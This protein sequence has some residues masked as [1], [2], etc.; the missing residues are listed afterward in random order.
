MVSGVGCQG[1]SILDCGFRIE[2]PNISGIKKID[3]GIANL[4]I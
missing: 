1:F 3:S 2:S 4:G